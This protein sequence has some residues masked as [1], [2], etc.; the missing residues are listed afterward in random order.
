MELEYATTQFFERRL[1]L[2]ELD[3]LVAMS[4]GFELKDLYF[5]YD[6]YF[7]VLQIY[8]KGTYYD[9]KGNILFTNDNALKGIGLD[10]NT[11]NENKEKLLKMQAGETFEFTINNNEMY[12]GEV[13]TYYAPF[14][15]CDRKAD[16]RLAWE[17][18]E[19]L[20]NS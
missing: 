8:E 20:L 15:T 16:Y 7:R 1:A 6:T 10:T 13:N 18:F 19:K 12:N 4:M 9:A 14:T 3:V 17:H 5:M 11:F 2:V